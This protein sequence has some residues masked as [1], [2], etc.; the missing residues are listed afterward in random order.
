MF[1]PGYQGEAE[2]LA[3]DL[4]LGA[5][6]AIPLDGMRPADLGRAKLVLIL[7]S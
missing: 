4:D 5:N 6:R 7:G 2:R 3:R 1:R